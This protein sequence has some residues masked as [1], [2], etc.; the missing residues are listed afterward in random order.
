MATCRSCG[1]DIIWAKTVTDKRMPVNDEP[2]GN[3]NLH[4]LGGLGYSVQI[5]SEPVCDEPHYLS[6][7]ATCPQADSWRARR[8]HVG[9]AR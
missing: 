6:H 4:L 9:S 2:S 1:A 5:C 8:R 3:G 7:Y